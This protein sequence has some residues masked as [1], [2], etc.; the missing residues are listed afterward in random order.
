MP[1]PHVYQAYGIYFLHTQHRLIR[2]LKRMHAPSVHGHK[3]W[4]SSFVLMDYLI[5]NPPRRGSR[6]MEIGCGWGPAAVF[7]AQRFDTKVTGVDMDPDVFPFLE[8]MAELNDVEIKTLES[9]F[10]DLS[11]RTL[12]QA[13]LIMGSDI[14]FW[15]NLVKPVFNL[16]KRALKGGTKRVVITD[17]GRPTFYELADLCAKRFDTELS[18]WYAVEPNR[19]TG[20]VLEI[21][22]SKKSKKLKD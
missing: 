8:V 1:E 4:Q 11:S 3:T 14:C 7:C 12:G 21:R 19:V 17:P 22:A 16:I 15:D 6:V 10:E 18:E 9:K 5:H 2:A 13:N 20:E